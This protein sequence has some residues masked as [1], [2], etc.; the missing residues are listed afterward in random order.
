M[1]Y[2]NTKTGAIINSHS[3]ISGKDWVATEFNQASQPEPDLLKKVE[4]VAENHSQDKSASSSEFDA[5]TIKQ[6]KQ[7]L[8]AF[9]VKYDPKAKKQELYDQMMKL[10]K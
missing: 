2:K 4:V 8:D 5:A 3:K 6:I 7:E 9:G 1:R 10:G